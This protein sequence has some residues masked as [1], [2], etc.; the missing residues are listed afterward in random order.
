MS[1]KNEW[2]GETKSGVVLSTYVLST[3]SMAQR[4]SQMF[5]FKAKNSKKITLI[6]N[7]MSRK[8]KL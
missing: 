5:F 4:N 6:D 1:Y 3:C 8:K 2:V 7:C